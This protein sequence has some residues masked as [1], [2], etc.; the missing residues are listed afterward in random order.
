MSAKVL[1][2]SKIPIINPQ[3]SLT[4]IDNWKDQLS[5]E[6]VAAL[7]QNIARSAV[8]KLHR[9][10]DHEDRHKAF[11]ATLRKERDD[12]QERIDQAL[13]TAKATWDRRLTEALT[14]QEA[15]HRTNL[16]AVRAGSQATVEDLQ[17]RL[18]TYEAADAI[19]C[20]EGFEENRG[21]VPHFPIVVNRFTMQA[22]YVK[23]IDQGRVMG[24]AGGPND[25]IFIQDLYVTPRIDSNHV[26][27][28][29]PAWFLSHIQANSDTYPLIIQEFQKAKDW[30]VHADIQWYY[31]CDS[32]L[33][34]VEEEITTLQAQ[35]EAL[36]A[37]LRCARF[38][39]ENADIPRRFSNLQALTP[40]SARRG[41]D[42]NDP[43][44]EPIR[45]QWTRTFTHGQ[46]PA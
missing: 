13:A 15:E 11:V 32:H 3:S 19:E 41:R 18:H 21:Q 17:H 22:Q 34:S 46:A 36:R 12:T 26:P 29:L 4:L 6:A 45:Y 25:A 23:Y 31:C 20:P 40:T 14:A 5:T 28:P 43:S 2:M 8:G 27:E 39:L 10:I 38:R 1:E 42:G 9:A 33:C 16:D 44:P 30:G 35:S 37:Q 24:T 7:A